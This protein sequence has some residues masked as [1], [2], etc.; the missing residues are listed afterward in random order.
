MSQQSVQWYLLCLLLRV[1]K[2][3]VGCQFAHQIGQLLIR[4]DGNRELR[5]V[6][7]EPCKIA[8]VVCL[9]THRVVGRVGN[10]VF[11]RH[12]V[13]SVVEIAQIPHRQG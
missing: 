2:P 3:G 7:G 9:H 4:L 13:G 6:F 10:V 5:A 8:L 12:I 1:I 11:N